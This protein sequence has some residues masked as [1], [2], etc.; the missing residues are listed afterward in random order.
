VHRSFLFRAKRHPSTRRKSK[1]QQDS[2]I[3]LSL[4]D[5][6]DLHL[7]LFDSGRY[8]LCRMVRD[9]LLFLVFKLV[10]VIFASEMGSFLDDIGSNRE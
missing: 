1:A 6:K 10:V 9:N 4:L 2:S 3:L 7:G 5:L 8:L